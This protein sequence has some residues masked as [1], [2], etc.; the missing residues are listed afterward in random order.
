MH[1]IKTAIAVAIV[2]CAV[3]AA[4]G[5]AIHDAFADYRRRAERDLKHLRDRDGRFR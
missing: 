5:V 2:L 3:V 4:L 1:D